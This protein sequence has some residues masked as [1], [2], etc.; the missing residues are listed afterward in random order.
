MNTSTT[1]YIQKTSRTCTSY[2]WTRAYSIHERFHIH[3]R[4][5]PPR[6]GI[7]HFANEEENSIAACTHLGQG[8]VDQRTDGKHTAMKTLLTERI[9]FR[10][11][12]CLRPRSH[13]LPT[14]ATHKVNCTEQVSLRPKRCRLLPHLSNSP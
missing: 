2:G 11:E 7:N 6:S 4:D 12:T 5:L 14:I 3:A 10:H 13:R 9:G 1:K 8:R